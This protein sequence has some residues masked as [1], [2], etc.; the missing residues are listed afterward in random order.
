M[1]VRCVY[2]YC[3][4]IT[5]LTLDV[6][7]SKDYSPRQAGNISKRSSG[8]YDIEALVR[9]ELARQ[10]EEEYIE[11][12]ERMHGQ[13]GDRPLSHALFFCVSHTHKS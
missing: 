1:I 7:K 10:E 12:W 5:A 2:A 13:V 9:R 3:V 6:I 11:L 8:K 4:L